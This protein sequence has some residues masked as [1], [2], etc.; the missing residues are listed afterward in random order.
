M[1]EVITQWPG[2][3]T[4]EVER[5]ITVPVEIGMNGIPNLRVVRSISL[6]GLSDVIMTF[7]D[8]TDPYFARQEVYE[9]IADLSLPAGR[10][11]HPSRHYPLRG[12]GLIP[13]GTCSRART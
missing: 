2:R 8:G 3:A 9:R 13:T 7:E 5:L 1:V 12:Q 10:L 4:E 11:P 6:Y